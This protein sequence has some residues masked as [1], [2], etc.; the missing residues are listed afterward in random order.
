MSRSLH[1]PSYRRHK[2]SGQAIVTLTNNLGERRDV[3][4]GKYGT[5]ESQA[6]YTRVLAEWQANG[7]RFPQPTA[8]GPDLTVNEL[9]LAFWQHAE[10]H[11]R[12]PDGTQ[13]AEIHCL[14]AALRPLLQLFG[15]TRVKDFGPLSLK[16]VRER[17][18]ESVDERTNRPWCRRTI[19]LHT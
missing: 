10:Q 19:N 12:R 14:R 5:P 13:T 7:R 18:I 17:M 4:L 3:L 15:H 8:V 16:A 1:I 11:Y 2:Q 6:E 9:I